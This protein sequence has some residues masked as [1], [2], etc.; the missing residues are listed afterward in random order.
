M[1]IIRYG[2]RDDIDVMFLDEYKYVV[3]NTQYCNFKTGQIKNPYDK[4]LYDVGFIG[5]GKYSSRNNKLKKPTDE[6]EVWT[7]IMGRCYHD[8]EKYPTYFGVSTVC[9][10]WH[11]FQNFA[12]WFNENKYDVCGRL[13]VD[14][15]ILFPNSKIYSPETCLLVP[16]RINMLFSNK[17]NNRGLPNGIY[18]RKSGK[19]SAK[20]NSK[21]LGVFNSLEEAYAA[22]AKE[23]ENKIKEVAD[24]YKSI[25][26]EHVYNALYNYKVDIANDKN[27]VA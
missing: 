17:A 16:Q 20:Y 12:E 21:E 3:T 9:E 18:K 6:Y 27:Y 15:D 14:K 4:S 25:I 24:E 19:Y 1:K 26:P 13:H 7:G 2:G 5:V 23:K 11:N 10:E 22:Y 8:K